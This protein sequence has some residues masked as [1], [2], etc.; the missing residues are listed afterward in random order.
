MAI[1]SHR[2]RLH[3]PEATVL[4]EFADDANLSPNVMMRRA[5]REYCQRHGYFIPPYADGSRCEAP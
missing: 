2:V 3:D 5:I 1:R 4:R